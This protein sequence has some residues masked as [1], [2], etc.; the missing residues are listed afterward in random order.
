ML[1]LKY[2]V[3]FNDRSFCLNFQFLKQYHVCHIDFLRAVEDMDVFFCCL[4]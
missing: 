2:C 3:T 4:Y 1:C